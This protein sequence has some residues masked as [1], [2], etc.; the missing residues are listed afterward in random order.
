MGV[1]SVIIVFYSYLNFFDLLFFFLLLFCILHNIACSKRKMC[2]E[3][4]LW[5][6]KVQTKGSPKWRFKKQKRQLIF[7]YS[8]WLLWKLHSIYVFQH[9]PQITRCQPQLCILC[10]IPCSRTILNV[11]CV[12]EAE[13]TRPIGREDF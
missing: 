10:P 6:F 8:D 4:V 11:L 3:S 7:C 13:S 12:C 2:N 1:L 5:G 9:H